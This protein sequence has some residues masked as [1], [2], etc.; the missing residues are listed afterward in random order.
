MA[1]Y[2]GPRFSSEVSIALK[3]NP[4]WLIIILHFFWSVPIEH[5]E[6]DMVQNWVP[7]KLDGSY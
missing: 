6:M 5:P 2:V 4:G 1:N 7:Q 3:N